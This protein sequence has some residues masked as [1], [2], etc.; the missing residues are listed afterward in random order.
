[1]KQEHS[2]AKGLIKAKH[3]HADV[4]EKEAKIEEHLTERRDKEASTDQSVQQL[5]ADLE[6]LQVSITGNA[7]ERESR[8][9]DVYAHCGQGEGVTP[10][11]AQLAHL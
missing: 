2:T 3:K 4:L 11:S 10:T 9:A 8:L 5:Q 7:K 6:N 1:M